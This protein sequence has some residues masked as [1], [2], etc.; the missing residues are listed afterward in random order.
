[1]T[2]VRV[3]LASGQH[4]DTCAENIKCKYSG[5]TDE[6]TSFNYTD[7]V[8]GIPIYLNINKVEA[9]VQLNADG[10]VNDESKEV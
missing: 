1:M 5:L 9:V 7:A 6:L 2:V 4:F 8:R 10:G 3:Y